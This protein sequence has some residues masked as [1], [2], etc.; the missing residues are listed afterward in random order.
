MANYRGRKL[1]HHG[2]N[3]DG[4]SS[5]VALLPEDGIGVVVLSN[6]YSSLVPWPI[7]LGAFDEVLG[8][9][10]LP[11][12]QRF[13]E[14]QEVGESGAQEAKARAHRVPDTRPSHALEDYAGRFSH[15]AYGSFDIEVENAVLRARFRTLSLTMRHR[16]YDVFSVELEGNE[17][18]Q[19]YAS[20]MTDPE[21]I[22]EAVSIPFEPTV[23]PIMFKRVPE[24]PSAE[25]CERLSGT[26]E[27]GPIEFTIEFTP[28][29]R[30]VARVAGRGIYRILPY[31]NMTFRLEGLQDATASFVL[32]E[33]GSV[34]EILVQPMGLFRPKR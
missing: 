12:G 22:I 28:P 31:K 9:E 6:R 21:G 26:Y 25:T 14:R 27:M 30:L 19:L 13:L 33:E 34:R 8:L 18:A 4:F 16:H 32:D 23:E 2:G 11:W 15:P 3:I 20:F 24:M 29:E 7:A 10:R 1:V 17:D 5:L